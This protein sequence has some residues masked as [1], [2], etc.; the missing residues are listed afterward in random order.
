MRIKIEKIISLCRKSAQNHGNSKKI[1]NIYGHVGQTVS[2]NFDLWSWGGIFAIHI[3]HSLLRKKFQIL[4]IKS[5]FLGKNYQVEI[6]YEQIIYK[7][8]QE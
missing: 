1:E 3:N 6:V 8:F 4:P 7:L 2:N 5:Y